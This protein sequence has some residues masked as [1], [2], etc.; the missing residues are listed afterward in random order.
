M[1]PVG[2]ISLHTPRPAE[3]I[4]RVSVWHRYLAPLY[5]IPGNWELTGIGYPEP[6]HG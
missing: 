6:G 3:A 4:V 5:L 2:W 1:V